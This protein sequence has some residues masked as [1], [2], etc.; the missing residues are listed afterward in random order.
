[1]KIVNVKVEMQQKLRD[2]EKSARNP[3][4]VKDIGSKK[5]LMGLLAIWLPHL[6]VHKAATNIHLETKGQY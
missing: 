2:A 4:N 5:M 3:K 6:F 1:M